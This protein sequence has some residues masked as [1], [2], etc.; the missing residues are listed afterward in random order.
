MRPEKAGPGRPSSLRRQWTLTRETG[1][2]E[3]TEEEVDMSV[4]DMKEEIWLMKEQQ[5]RSLWVEG[6]SDDPLSGYL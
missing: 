6:L 4:S 5:R 3:F 1:E 2:I